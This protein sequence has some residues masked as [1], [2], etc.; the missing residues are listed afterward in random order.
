MFYFLDFFL[1]STRAAKSL[2]FVLPI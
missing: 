2:T 1:A